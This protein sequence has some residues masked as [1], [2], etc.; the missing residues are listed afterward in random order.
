MKNAVID[1]ILT[2]RSVRKFLNKPVEEDKLDLIL[3]A[4]TYAP[5]I[6]PLIL[7]MSM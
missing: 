5:A 6:S 3:E 7:T 1:N 2:R 4:G